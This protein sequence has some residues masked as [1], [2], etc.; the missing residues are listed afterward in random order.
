MGA[1]GESIVEVMVEIVGLMEG[2]IGVV[3]LGLQS[4]DASIA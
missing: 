2:G 4:A 3:L 1:G